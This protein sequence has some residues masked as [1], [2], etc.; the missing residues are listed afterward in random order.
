MKKII[1]IL[2]LVLNIGAICKANNPTS[3]YPRNE[4]ADIVDSR[5]VKS[6]QTFNVNGLEALSNLNPVQ[7]EFVYPY[8]HYVS[9]DSIHHGYFAQDVQ[10]GMPEN[11]QELLPP[12]PEMPLISDDKYLMVYDPSDIPLYM[13]EA[14]KELKAK[15]AELEARIEVLEGA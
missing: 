3:G 2:F 10:K 4:W 14:I 11:I 13:I 9:S 7:Y 15:I 1:V 12:V 8:L 5:V 6:T